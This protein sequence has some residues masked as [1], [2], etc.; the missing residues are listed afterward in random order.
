MRAMVVRKPG[1]PDALVLEDIAP[2]PL[3]RNDVR[4]RV[5][6]CGVCY[7]DIVTRNGTMRRGVEMP[8]IPGHEV[9]GIVESVGPDVR[10]FRPGDRV[11]TLQRRHICGHCKHCRNDQ[12][13]A[14][15]ER[16][17]LGDAGLN[18]GYSELVCVEQDNVALVPDN[19]DLASAAIVAC[20]VGSELN[21]IR[22]VA[23]LRAGERL[24]IN[25]AG[26][27][28]GIH[29]VQLAHIS[30]AE[31]IAVTGSPQKVEA[32]RAAGADHVVLY[33]RGEDF[34][35]KVRALTGGEGV[36]VAV[37]NVGSHTFERDAQEPRAARTLD[38][39][40]AA[41][42]RFREAQP[43]AA[44]LPRHLDPERAEHQPASVPGLPRPGAPR[45][46]EADGLDRDAAGARRG[47]APHGGER[48]AHRPHPAAAVAG[49]VNRGDKPMAM[50]AAR[51]IPQL[52]DELAARFPDRDALIDGGRRFTFATMRDRVEDIARGLVAL[53]VGRGDKVAILMG[54]RAEWVL[55][56]LAILSLGAVMVGVNTWSTTRELDYVL[57]QSDT[58]VLVT[59]DRFLKSDYLA[60]L[61]ELRPWSATLPQLRHVVVVGGGT[62]P[63]MIGFDAMV[64]AGAAVPREEVRT[65]AAAVLPEDLAYLLYTSGST[66][67][68]KGVMLLQRP[69]IENLYG[70]GAR[71]GIDETDRLWLVISLFWG[72][73]CSNALFAAFTHGACVVLQESF[74]PAAALRIMEAE[75][76]TVFYGTGNIV[77]ALLEHPDFAARDLS[78]LRKGATIGTPDQMRRVMRDLLPQAC[79]IF[80][81]TETYGNCAVGDWRDP[82]EVRATAVG[83]VL[84]G[85][86]FRIVDVETGD[87]RESGTGELRVKGHVT[88]GY[89]KD[90]ERTAEAFDAEGWF[91]TGDLSHIDE[92][93]RLHFRTRL[94]EMLKTGGINVS[95]AEVQDVLL[96]HPAVEQAHVV[97]LPDE[98]RGEIVAAVIVLKRGAPADEAGLAAHCRE[99]LAAYKVPRRFRIVEST[100]LPLT[101]TGK[102]QRNRLHMLFD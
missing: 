26:G 59:G 89:Y 7:H 16:E 93:G 92:D 69:L 41:Q 68:P 4:I 23:R 36:D 30:G 61:D 13:T 54:N 10:V 102:L 101:V 81:L 73:G 39:H 76:C 96:Q 65:R 74:E 28:L 1:G 21:A 31:V 24:L 60:Q 25:G 45:A 9:S 86:A 66:A 18:G 27:G 5:E 22:D 17:F 35:A 47:R 88:P 62:R 100:E 19:V 63:D 75:R 20:T 40:R 37:D 91:R 80:G 55:T 3:R 98:A 6:A 2:P 79:Q 72:L 43:R 64:A 78:A 90:P 48:G 12:E 56:D 94:K 99:A 46:G 29:G 33:D 97:G 50:P 57:N 32:I 11:A 87:V 77:Q 15:A 49:G 84:P 14:C 51:T 71:L 34:S 67:R 38:L 83:R 52:I 82:D 85:S 58:C 44:V 42:R 8:F 95:P 53:G 70:I